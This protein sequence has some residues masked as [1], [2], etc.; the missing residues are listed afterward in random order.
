MYIVQFTL[1]SLYC[2]DCTVRWQSHAFS[3]HATE[4]PE[5]ARKP[6]LA[7]LP[8]Q[9]VYAVDGCSNFPLF[10]AGQFIQQCARTFCWWRIP[11][12]FWMAQSLAA[13]S[14]IITFSL[15]Q[16]CPVYIAR[17]T[18]SSVQCTLDNV[19][20]PVYSVYCPV[21]S[22]QNRV[23]SSSLLSRVLLQHFQFTLSVRLTLHRPLVSASNKIIQNTVHLKQVWRGW[24]GGSLK[25]D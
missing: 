4:L 8:G 6:Q 17:C 9:L 15:E 3:C 22:A 16:Q 24:V 23:L 5:E 14:M 12:N 10:K 19:Q 25:L 18:L 2:P 7:W 20:F 21:S 11:G 13:C 1:S